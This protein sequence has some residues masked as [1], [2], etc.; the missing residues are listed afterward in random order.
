VTLLGWEDGVLCY[1]GLNSLLCVCCCV[2]VYVCVCMCVCRVK[3][4]AACDADSV[5][6]FFVCLFLESFVGLA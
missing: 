2:C 3:S 4:R 6:L 5:S 1:A